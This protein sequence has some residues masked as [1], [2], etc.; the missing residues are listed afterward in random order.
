ML[1]TCI[2]RAASKGNEDGQHRP[3]SL[4]QSF[5]HDA[6]KCEHESIGK[7]VKIGNPAGFILFDSN[8]N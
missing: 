2:V 5:N 6:L 8:Q 7:R 1:A 3:V 4:Y